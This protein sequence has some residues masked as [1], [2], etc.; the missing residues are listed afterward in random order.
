MNGKLEKEGYD[1]LAGEMM[2]KNYAIFHINYLLEQLEQCQTMD[3]VD[4]KVREVLEDV[5]K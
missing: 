1:L 2:T 5:W 3:E 4:N